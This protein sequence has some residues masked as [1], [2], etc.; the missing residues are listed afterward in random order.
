MKYIT[1]FLFLF[2]IFSSCEKLDPDK[3]GNLVPATV[4]ENPALSSIQLSTT[5][6][7]YQTYGEEDSSKI[8]ILEGG[9]GDD[10]LYLLELNKTVNNWNLSKNYQVIY[11]DYRGCGLSQRHPLSEL[12]MQHTLE[13]LEELIDKFAPNEKVILIGHSYGGVVA[14]QY[15][16]QHPER[17]KGAVFIEP[18]ALSVKINKNLS[19]ANNVNLLGKDINEIIWIKQMIGMD[20]HE[21]ADYY[22][23]V[24]R[25]NRQNKKRGVS[26]PFLNSRGGAAS[27]IA[28]AINEVSSGDYD[29]TKNLTNYSDSVLFISSD[30]SDLGYDFQEKEQVYFFNKHK[31]IKIT[32]SGHNGL[33]NC[34]TDQTLT[35]IKTYLES[36]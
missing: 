11:H 31:H 30:Q 35:H 17:V 15:I 24:A 21:K 3:P 25:I 4:I 1:L 16:N 14:A 29:Y 19:V 27:A 20:N 9:P 7:Y 8:F 34:Q 32:E 26:C 10:F 33:I 5:K 6:L 23:A 13:D 36:L 12:T 28:I 2:W 18:G 22:Y